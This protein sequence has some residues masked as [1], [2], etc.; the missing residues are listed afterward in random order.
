MA[1]I[2]VYVKIACHRLAQPAT[3]CVRL[4]LSEDSLADEPDCFLPGA[5]PRLPSVAGPG[6]ISHSKVYESMN[7]GHKAA[8]KKSDARR[9]NSGQT[10]AR[11]AHLST[12]PEPL[13]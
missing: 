7:P 6:C 13:S 10:L 9:I 2:D 1:P 12:E 5:H 11:N 4:R 8:S 3:V